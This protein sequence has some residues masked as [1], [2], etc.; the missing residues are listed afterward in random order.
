MAQRSA[1][2]KTPSVDISPKNLEV[3]QSLVTWVYGGAAG[4]GGKW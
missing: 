2:S 1:L 4:V 3:F